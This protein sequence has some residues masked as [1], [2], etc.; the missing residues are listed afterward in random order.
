MFVVGVVYDKIVLLWGVADQGRPRQLARLG[1]HTGPVAA[2]AFS[3]DGKTV[4]TG[5]HDNTVLLWDLTELNDLRYH[6]IQHACA[7]TGRGLNHDEWTQYVSGPSY[8]NTCAP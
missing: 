3:P 4:A 2:V 6:A 5:S 8:P 1:G 7:L